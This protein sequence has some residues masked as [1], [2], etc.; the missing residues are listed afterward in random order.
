MKATRLN[1]AQWTQMVKPLLSIALQKVGIIEKLPRVMVYT[2]RQY[3]GLGLNHPWCNQQ[4]KHL[5]TL[6]GETANKTPTELLLQAS[7][8]L[9]RL[10]IGSPVTFKDVHRKRLK[11]TLTSTWLIDLL[12]FWGDN[13]IFLH[14]PLPQLQLQREFDILLMQCFLLE[15]PTDTELRRLMDYRE[16]LQVTILSDITT[17]DGKDILPQS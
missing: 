5:Y 16:Y 6:I 15:K 10:E 4:L 14:D 11:F 13:D 3:Y 9:L 17:V 2:S 12:Y 8:E 7:A 1:K